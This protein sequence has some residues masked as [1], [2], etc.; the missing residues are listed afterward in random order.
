MIKKFNDWAKLEE[1][2]NGHETDYT[3]SQNEYDISESWEI[4]DK[5]NLN[6]LD[7]HSFTSAISRDEFINEAFPDLNE[8]EDEYTKNKMYALYETQLFYTHRENWFKGPKN[9]N[10][11][12]IIIESTTHA[13]IFHNDQTFAISKESY[14]ILMNENLNEDW[15]IFGIG[16]AISDTGE[17]VASAVS[18]VVDTA[19]DW[20]KSLGDAAGSVLAFI[21]TCYEAV[22][23]F[24]GDDWLTMIQ[25]L[26]TLFRGIWGTIGTVF[27]PGTGD[28]VNKIVGGATGLVSVYTGYTRIKDP[29]SNLKTAISSAKSALDVGTGL[30]EHGPLL[31]SGANAI[32]VGAK[33]VIGVLKSSPSILSGITDLTS[34]FTGKDGALKA[35]GESFFNIKNAKGLGGTLLNM[36][37][38]TS[39]GGFKPDVILKNLQP[40][41]ISLGGSI[42]LEYL[43]PKDI[44]ETVLGSAKTIITAVDTAF[45]IPTKAQ[46]FIDGLKKTEEG[47]MKYLTDAV[48]GIGEPVVKGLKNFTNAI[49]PTVDSVTSPISKFTTGHQ[50][51]L[52]ALKSNNLNVGLSVLNIEE[53]EAV[54]PQK[55]I[56]I[57]KKEIKILKK[58]KS[59]IKTKLMKESYF[60]NY[61]KW[62]K[63][64]NN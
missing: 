47:T 36:S 15:D 60:D 28:I 50:K 18:S 55:P 53:T 7:E 31:L 8:S 43:V 51:T 52:Q 56:T 19:G 21:K 59:K 45:S 2:G 24:A 34:L 62:L 30:A 13:V 49:K 25:T 42:A 57:S 32:V 23:S 33:D 64:N 26:S 58:N 63:E 16:K 6:R 46:E 48:V 37:N 17:M 41:L 61:E 54:E 20:A 44:K 14:N 27:T 5:P 3:I 29:I 9:K 38:I 4:L 40:Q 10:I 12:P 39:K 1:Q 22:K 35:E 11:V